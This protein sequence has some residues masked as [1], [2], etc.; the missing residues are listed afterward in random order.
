MI[1]DTHQHVFWHGRDDAALVADMDACGIRLAWL[2][3]WEI[4]PWPSNPD[5]IAYAHILN[6]ARAR[7]DGATPGIVLEDLLVAHRRFPGRFVLGWCPDPSLP[8]AVEMFEAAC[9]MHGVRVCGEWKFRMLFDDPR[10]LELFRA[11]GRRRAPVVLHLDVPYL[12]PCGSQSRYVPSW[13]GGTVDNLARALR[14]CPETVFIGHA[15]GFWREISADADLDP[16]PYPSGPL[17]RGGRI[18]ALLSEHPNL[19]ADL[20]AGSAL[21]ALKRDSGYSRELLERFSDRF[22]FARDY[23]GGELLEF[24]RGLSLSTSTLERVLSGNALRLVDPERA[25]QPPALLQL[26]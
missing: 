17:I 10:C 14:A 25:Q 23:Y 6:P 4:P 21:R 3:S 15:P 2:L 11:A 16:E 5:A 18:E 22:L 19:M 24:L 20:S 7:P 12:P 13:Y 8:R 26:G 1:I 9:D